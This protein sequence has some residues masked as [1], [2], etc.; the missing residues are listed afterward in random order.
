MDESDDL[1]RA[2]DALEGLRST[3]GDS[4]VES[5]KLS[6]GAKIAELDEGVTRY[7]ERRLVSALFADFAGFTAMVSRGDPESVHALLGSAFAVLV[8]VIERYGGTIEKFIGDGIMALFGAPRSREDDARR[9][10]LASLEMRM[11][12]ERFNRER[13]TNLGLHFGIGTG[14]VIAGRVG[15]AGHRSYAAVG[16]A[17]NRA[18]RLSSCT[19]AGEIYA[20]A[21]TRALAGEGCRF[22]ELPKTILKGFDQPVAMHRLESIPGCDCAAAASS[23]FVGREAE[24]SAMMDAWR[25][26]EKGSLQI[27]ISGEPGIGKSRLVSEWL[28]RMRSRKSG[29]D[30]RSHVITI[31]THCK[32]F[33]SSYAYGFWISFIEELAGISMADSGMERRDRLSAWLLELGVAEEDRAHV[34]SLCG[35]AERPDPRKASLSCPDDEEGDY[36]AGCGDPSRAVVSILAALASGI[37][38]V[39][40]CDDWQWSDPSS[41]SLLSRLFQGAYAGSVAW[42]TVSR[43]REAFAGIIPDAP[44]KSADPSESADGAG[45][46]LFL[47]MNLGPLNE[48]EC[49]KLAESFVVHRD[50]SLPAR[51]AAPDLSYAGGNPLFVEELARLDSTVRPMDG[52]KGLSGLRPGLFGLITARIDA[53]PPE[54]AEA[55]RVAAVLGDHFPQRLLTAMGAKADPEKLVTVGI[56]ARATDGATLSFRHGILRE[57]V[58][59]YFPEGALR[60]LHGRAAAAIKETFPEYVKLRPETLARHWHRAGEGR[61][62][63]PYYKTA[64]EELYY[65]NAFPEAIGLLE[66]GIALA[67][68]TGSVIHLAE[69]LGLLGGSY[70]RTG[71]PSKSLP[72]F[73]EALEIQR[74]LSNR[75][76]EISLER[77]KAYALSQAG[78]YAQAQS[79]LESALDL[80]RQT[81]RLKDEARIFDDLAWVALKKGD[82]ETARTFAQKASRTADSLGMPY[83]QKR[84]EDTLTACEVKA[85]LIPEQY[86][87]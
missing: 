48:A 23:P 79:L 24:L 32:S 31:W 57:A 71:E 69:F 81:R 67:R 9:A 22:T 87:A 49:K 63:L 83:L 41:R 66:T 1:R 29:K 53:L 3:L 76:K 86:N 13:G 18:A 50:E 11:A 15:P 10:C 68:E 40:I 34:F 47:D 39:L 42:I 30:E 64:A 60:E 33:D 61:K 62:A 72:L 36:S 56:L 75:S 17:V 37:R 46:Q 35:N 21:A 28:S 59:A 80:A 78:E 4:A 55:V 6:L 45:T 26:T 5:A 12:L 51:N 82:R 27:L 43:E 73:D 74:K 44:A 25:R 77:G 19:S 7:G 54:L 2:I 38:L 8:P 20:D 65:R 84:A 14:M 58:Y 85:G 16:D 52:Q 70:A